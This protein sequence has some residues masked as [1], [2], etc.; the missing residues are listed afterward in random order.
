MAI[1]EQQAWALPLAD[2]AK[3]IEAGEGIVRATDKPAEVAEIEKSYADF[4]AATP[5]FRQSPENIQTLMNRIAW[6]RVPTVDDLTQAHALAVY[7]K[8]YAPVVQAE[9]DPEKMSLQQLHEAAFGGP[10]R[11]PAWT[12]D[13]ALLKK[14]SG[15][16]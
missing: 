3:A 9:T 13:L 2:V 14:A 16:R 4:V 6:T 5:D 8:E 7:R 11:D 15:V 10:E 1:T 12:M